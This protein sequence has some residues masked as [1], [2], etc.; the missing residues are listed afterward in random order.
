[1]KYWSTPILAKTYTN[2]GNPEEVARV[3]RNLPVIHVT[4]WNPDAAC[5][6]I[7]PFCELISDVF[8]ATQL[9]QS[10]SWLCVSKTCKLTL[11]A[12]QFLSH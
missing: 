4:L 1:M 11:A 3:Q 9:F 12:V 10:A 6:S 2:V 7:I 8:A 5:L